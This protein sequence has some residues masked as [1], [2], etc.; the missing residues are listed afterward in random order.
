VAGQYFTSGQLVQV[1][2][3]QPPSAPNFVSANAPNLAVRPDGTFSG[4]FELA[5]HHGAAK[6][7]ACDTAG[8]CA[9]VLVT[10][11]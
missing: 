6:I 4:S 9:T 11:P 5:S 10:A 2:L 8:I 3:Y 1:F 7:K